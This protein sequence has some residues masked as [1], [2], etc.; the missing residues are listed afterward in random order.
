MF[1]SPY[2][3]IGLAFVALAAAAAFMI[4]PTQRLFAG[5][6]F[7]ISTSL[8]L[9]FFSLWLNENFGPIGIIH[10][11]TV[12]VAALVV[13]GLW[14][15]AQVSAFARQLQQIANAVDLYVLPRSLTDAQKELLAAYLLTREKG[16]ITVVYPNNDSE[17]HQYAMQ[18]YSAFGDGGWRAVPKPA[19]RPSEGVSIKHIGNDQYSKKTDM[20]RKAFEAA[21]IPINGGGWQN[22]QGGP[23]SIE[24]RVG[25]RPLQVQQPVTHPFWK[26]QKKQVSPLS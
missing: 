6:V 13:C 17:A 21:N 7:W 8:G 26:R 2:L 4:W 9:V 19:D 23:E 12:A 25:R 24:L 15:A 16:E 11:G 14:L 22:A 1:A 20:L 10:I 3:S 5:S 18:F